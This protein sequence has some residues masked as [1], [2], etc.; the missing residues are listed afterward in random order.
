MSLK[1]ISMQTYLTILVIIISSL[2]RLVGLG[3]V[4][5]GFANDEVSYILSG[6]TIGQTG[7]FDI[8]G[9]FLPLSVNLDSSLSPVPVYLIT[10]FIKLFGLTTFIVRLPFALMGVGASVLVFLLCRELFNKNNR[11]ALISSLVFSFSSWNIF[12]TRGVWDVV[13]AQFFYLLG[14]YIFLKKL[15]KG[16]FSWSLPA[17][18]LGFF[19]YHGTKVFFLFFIF[20]LIVVYWR[21]LVARKKELIFFGVGILAIFAL[22]AVVLNTQ[23]VTRQTEIV[24]SNKSV[25]EDARKSV[26][27]DRLRSNAPIILRQVLSN[28][29]TYFFQKMSGNYLGAFSPQYLF[30][31]GDINPIVAYG[32]FFKGVLYLID[33]PFLILGFIF[34]FVKSNV[35][36]ESNLDKE[37]VGRYQ[38]SLLVVLGS[39]L[40][41]PLPSTFGAGTTYVIRAFMMTPFLSILIGLG[42]YSCWSIL[43]ERNNYRI[44]FVIGAIV[45]YAL[46]IGRFFYQYYYQFNSSGG[47]F[48]NVSSRELSEYIIN[49]SSK[50]N[51]VVVADVE[52]KVLLQY[53]FFSKANVYEFQKAWKNKWPATLGKVTFID[54][55]PNVKDP[56]FKLKPKTLYATKAE[57]R[58]GVASIAEIKD[59]MEP[60]RTIWR[61][62]EE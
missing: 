58:L 24:F 17:F 33:L 51:Q 41:A 6:Y 23:L 48:W 40:I 61:F 16:G 35:F 43:S 22:F 39:L 31:I 27:F 52:D 2:L 46:F 59:P 3:N 62:Y 49:N 26:N 56:F 15:N 60:L 53:A 54:S 44:T 14:F 25:L 10:L 36:K 21:K 34:L 19:S 11:I 55:C 4:P 57:C 32:I 20:L 18:L 30:T 13:P 9:K 7:G 1:K 37:D 5:H 8:A 28:K 42:L 50:Y 12:V 47:E 29:V 45:F 38:R